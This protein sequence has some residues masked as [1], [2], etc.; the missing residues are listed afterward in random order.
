[1]IIIYAVVVYKSETQVKVHI[2]LR[3]ITG[4][5]VAK[6]RVTSKE[7]MREFLFGHSHRYPKAHKITYKGPSLSADKHAELVKPFEDMFYAWHGGNTTT[8]DALAFATLWQQQTQQERIAVAL[9]T[10]ASR[11]GKDYV[12]D[13]VSYFTNRIC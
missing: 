7:E 13:I 2:W 3:T 6:T 10:I 9:E 4:Q 5:L 11:L 12:F 8:A 1:M